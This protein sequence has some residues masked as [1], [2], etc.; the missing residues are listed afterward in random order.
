MFSAVINE[1][2]TFLVYVLE[3]DIIVIGYYIHVQLTYM[4]TYD[5]WNI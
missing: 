3:H 2:V 1:R 5:Q 4:W